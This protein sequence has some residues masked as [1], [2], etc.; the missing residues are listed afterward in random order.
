MIIPSYLPHPA[1]IWRFVCKLFGYF[2]ILSQNLPIFMW[3]CWI[4]ETRNW[5]K[6]GDYSAAN[7]AFPWSMVNSR[8]GFFA[9]VKWC[10]IGK[11]TVYEFF[12]RRYLRRRNFMW[13][14]NLITIVKF[15][16]LFSLFSIFFAFGGFGHSALS[17]LSFVRFLVRCLWRHNA[18]WQGQGD[19][20]RGRERTRKPN[21]DQK[22]Y[23]IHNHTNWKRLKER[24]SGGE[25]VPVCFHEKDW[26]CG[27][28]GFIN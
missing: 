9:V 28:T 12:G 10:N 15:D 7:I 27:M 23:K 13:L 3:P 17:H 21:E 22:T 6:E 1:L 19:N 26:K 25:H 18:T 24:I 14:K 8:I 2:S 16:S 11:S 20:S 4:P 5:R